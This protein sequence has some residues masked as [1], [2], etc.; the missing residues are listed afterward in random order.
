MS[1]PQPSMSGTTREAVAAYVIEILT[2]LTSE[3]DV[4]PI[5]SST[6]L[7]DLEL[8]SIS[9]VMLIGEIQHRY[10]L[11]DAVFERLRKADLLIVNLGV[12]ELVDIVCDLLAADSTATGSQG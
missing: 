7:R 6:R 2:D 3:W 12:G 9:L 1:A 4:A 8:E 10:R 5:T 11:G